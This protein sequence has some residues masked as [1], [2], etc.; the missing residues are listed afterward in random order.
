MIVVW[1]TFGVILRLPTS[2]A[3]QNPHARA[4]HLP[5]SHYFNRQSCEE[6]VILPLKKT[7]LGVLS[8]TRVKV[9]KNLHN[10][11]SLFGS[12]RAVVAAN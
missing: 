6:T 11:V 10:I 8:N 1:P 9:D 5:I 2:I 4:I 3:K 12:G 7:Y